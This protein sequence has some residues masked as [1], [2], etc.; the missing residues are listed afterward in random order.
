MKILLVEDYQHTR[1]TIAY[2]LKSR[3]EGVEIFES[4]NG[5]AALNFIKDGNKA[6]V[7]L[8]DISMPVMNGIDASKKI[9]E[10]NPDIKIIMLTSFNE[11][12][13]VFSSFNSGANA[14]CLK[15]IKLDEL[16][17]VINSVMNGAL[18]IDP[19][20][21]QYILQ[22]FKSES[23]V[24]TTKE[25]IIQDFDLTAREKDILKL[26]ALGKSNKDIAEDL[27]LS[28]HTVKNHLK[29]ILHKMSV[30]DRTQAAILAIKENLV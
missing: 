18:W 6:D 1:K 17:N 27:V 23:I 24:D 15:N 12:E 28:I 26:V 30:E 4:D 14:Y 22:I 2:G 10:I 5:L 8:M 13:H 21:A 20:I 29:N 25:N 9:K 19:S 11:K 3:L 16:V 7:V